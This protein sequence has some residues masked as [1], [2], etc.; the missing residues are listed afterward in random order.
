MRPPGPFL[1]TALPPFQAPVYFC[2]HHAGRASWSPCTP[3]CPHRPRPP[4]HPHLSGLSTCSARPRASTLPARDVPGRTCSAPRHPRV[5]RHPLTHLP[6][7][8]AVTAVSEATKRAPRSSISLQELTGKGKEPELDAARSVRGC[9]RCERR[10]AV[11]QTAHLRA[12]ARVRKR[13]GA[14]LSSTEGRRL[15]TDPGPGS[16]DFSV[17]LA[18]PMRVLQGGCLHGS[19]TSR[20][21]PSRT[22]GD[23]TGPGLGHR[24]R[25]HHALPPAGSFTPAP[26]A[27]SAA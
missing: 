17:P 10:P 18:V 23:H 27:P 4:R 25:G 20:H 1:P 13:P 24:A 3:P 15:H 2:P 7:R 16:Q 19:P 14:P 21:G 5:S 26:P 8:A 6:P 9:G 11:P 12:D 22:R